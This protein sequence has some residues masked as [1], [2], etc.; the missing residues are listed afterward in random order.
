MTFPSFGY[1]LAVAPDDVGAVARLFAERDIAAADIGRVLSGTE[2]AIAD[3]GTVEVIWDFE[4]EPLIGPRRQ[5]SVA[6]SPPGALRVA[7]LAHSTNPRGGVV[8][9]LELGDALVRLGCEPVVHAPDARAG[10]FFRPTLCRSVLVAASPV[11]GDVAT[12][13]ETRIAE[14]L[15]HFETAANRR[16]DVFHA[17]DGIS[18]NA[19]AALKQQGLIDRFARTVHHIDDFDDPKIAA[20]QARSIV[21]ADELFVVSGTWRDI[22][23]QR[24]GRNATMVGN[25][26]DSTRFAPRP[27]GREQALRTRLGLGEGPVFLSIGGIEERKNTLR[28]LEAFGEIRAVE[29]R[30]AIDRCGRR[31]GAR[32]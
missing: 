9:A 16:F 19:L 10:G 32:P 7:I 13:I 21:A 12:M 11:G 2:V 25:G 6:L 28:L 26:V 4:R 5:E 8:H 20:L 1:L 29:S 23:R 24:F 15:A 30:R 27:D 14:Y 18:A 3:R 22:V 31:F 17:Q